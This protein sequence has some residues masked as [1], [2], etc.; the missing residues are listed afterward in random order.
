MVVYDPEDEVVEEVDGGVAVP[1]G[2]EEDNDGNNIVPSGQSGHVDNSDDED[3]QDDVCAVCSN[4]G[5]LLVCDGCERDY[6]PGCAGDQRPFEQAKEDDLW[7]CSTC[8]SKQV[9]QLQKLQL[10]HQQQQQQQQQQLQQQPQHLHE[11]GGPHFCSMCGQ[12]DD[13]VMC[14]RCLELFHATCVCDLRAI[15]WGEPNLAWTC[16]A[17]EAQSPKDR[18]QQQQLD[19]WLQQQQV[20]EW[21]DDSGLGDGPA[22][23]DLDHA[24][25]NGLNNPVYA[26]EDAVCFACNVGGE[27]IR[28]RCAHCQQAFHPLCAGE[29]RSFDEVVAD[30][31]VCQSCQIDD[32]GIVLEPE[33]SL[34]ATDNNSSSSRAL[35]PSGGIIT[36][37]DKSEVVKHLLD[38]DDDSDSEDG[39]DSDIDPD[40]EDN[41]FS[42]AVE[43][44]DRPKVTRKQMVEFSLKELFSLRIARKAKSLR[45]SEAETREA[46]RKFKERM[47]GIIE[48]AKAWA[49]SSKPMAYII[50]TWLKMWSVDQWWS[51][52]DRS[53]SKERQIAMGHAAPNMQLDEYDALPPVKASELRGWVIYID[54]TFDQQESLLRKYVGSATHTEQGSWARL[55]HYEKV[56][57]RKAY[58]Q[59]IAASDAK[60]A[61]F[62][63]AIKPT[64][65]VNFRVL[66]TP[67]MDEGRVPAI[68]LEGFYTMGHQGFEF[69]Y[70]GEKWTASLE[71]CTLEA[72]PESLRA[73]KPNGL[74]HAHQFN[75]GVRLTDPDQRMLSVSREDVIEAYESCETGLILKPLYGRS[76]VCSCC[77]REKRVQDDIFAARNKWKSNVIPNLEGVLIC[78]RCYMSWL[79]LRDGRQ[80]R[81]YIPGRYAGLTPEEF[82]NERRVMATG[83]PH[84]QLVHELLAQG[85]NEHNC[86]CCMIDRPLLVE[87]SEWREVNWAEN[88]LAGLEGP[89]ICGPC[90]GV[91]KNQYNNDLS[92]QDFV[93]YRRSYERRHRGLEHFDDLA[94]GEHVCP[95]CLIAKPVPVDKHSRVRWWRPNC[96]PNLDGPRMCDACYAAFRKKKDDKSV[97]DWLEWRRQTAVPSTKRGLWGKGSVK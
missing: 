42:G 49:N 21:N 11:D 45:L 5:S 22:N 43:N 95:A 86:P 19:G 23:D 1:S 47:C 14:D 7:Y 69:G 82:V 60:G 70:C 80:F 81:T 93:E 16:S 10:Q 31:L 73:H 79:T 87:G 40:E 62:W 38:H 88:N 32:S 36:D 76:L 46:L 25:V 50:R 4:Y 89:M 44:H 74:N 34:G 39:N 30:R 91:R 9:Q 64:V 90:D 26:G 65:D 2:Q 97:A 68:I 52:V 20:D 18:L 94:G 66:S 51:Y 27:L 56:F 61:H 84:T 57:R 67:A 54:A 85:H 83:K 13:L 8:T 72:L 29:E 71:R 96:I 92:D 6:H 35:V 48:G 37:Y 3:E 53:T 75:Q 77:R 12:P 28:L 55:S 24:G 58:G 41:G 63:Q 59:E 78:E 33:A 15:K 17:C